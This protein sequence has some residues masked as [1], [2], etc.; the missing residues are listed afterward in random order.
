MPIGHSEFLGSESLKEEDL[1]MAV[2]PVPSSVPDIQQLSKYSLN[3]WF[4]E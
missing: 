2:S 3:E 1:F 4:E